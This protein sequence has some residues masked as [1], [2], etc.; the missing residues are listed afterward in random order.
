MLESSEPGQEFHGGFV[1]LFSSMARNQ[2]RECRPSNRTPIV[3]F[4]GDVMA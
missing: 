4:H 2:A 1:A 3:R